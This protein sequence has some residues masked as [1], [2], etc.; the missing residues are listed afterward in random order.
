MDLYY[1]TEKY[2]TLDRKALCRKI[3]V[4]SKSEIS[5]VAQVLGEFF[6]QTPTGWYHDRCEEEIAAYRGNTSAKSLAGK[7][8]AE[9]KRLRRLAALLAGAEREANAEPKA[10]EQDGNSDSTEF[11]QDGNSDSTDGQRNSTNLNQ[12]QNLNQNTHTA[13]AVD[14]PPDGV[15]VPVCVLVC[16]K[17]Q[18]AG[19]GDANASDKVLAVLLEKG[20]DVAMFVDAAAVAVGKN[21]GFAYAVGIVQN[22]MTAAAALANTAMAVPKQ[23]APARSKFDPEPARVSDVWHESLGG[24]DRM[25]AELGIAPIDEVMETRPAFK[26]RVMAAANKRLVNVAA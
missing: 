15:D 5:A 8:S 2:L 12:N 20:A 10:T 26:A 14:Q 25:A 16:Q 23:G 6:L 13:P 9:A 1:D 3:V 11:Q 18:E 7:A 24:V 19:I 17:M 21:K 22:K 4:R